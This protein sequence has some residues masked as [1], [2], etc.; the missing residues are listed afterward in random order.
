MTTSKQGFTVCLVKKAI[1]QPFWKCHSK[2]TSLKCTGQGVACCWVL[3]TQC[4]C[5]YLCAC[6]CGPVC[7]YVSS[8][9]VSSG[10]CLSVC[11]TKSQSVRQRV[12]QS[13]KLSFSESVY[14][15][16]YSQKERKRQ[17]DKNTLNFMLTFQR[18]ASKRNCMLLNEI[19]LAR[20]D[21]LYF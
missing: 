1:R 5:L 7:V 3:K 16:V 13:D 15:L 4:V 20:G 2:G 8:A 6:F 12:S 18:L 9:P 14:Q 11:Q 17:R 19:F 21:H 10:F